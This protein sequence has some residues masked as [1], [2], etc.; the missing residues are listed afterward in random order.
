MDKFGIRGMEMKLK[1]S[2]I[3]IDIVSYFSVLMVFTMIVVGVVVFSSWKSSSEEM[4]EMHEKDAHED[5]FTKMEAYLNIPLHIN[6]MS[7]YSIE[8]EIVDIDN[9]REREI[10]FAGILKSTNPNVYSFSYGTES[11]EYYGARRNAKNEIEIMRSDK[12]TLGNSTYYAAK[13]DLTAGEVV[14]RLGKFDP[15][16]RDWYQIAKEKGEPVFSPTYTHFVMNDLAISAAYPIYD[17]EGM[18]KGVLGTHFILSDINEYLNEIV[19]PKN[20][21]VFIFE[22]NT[23][24]VIAST[25]NLP[26]FIAFQDR[27]MERIKIDQ[28][29]NDIFSKAYQEYQ[30]TSKHEFLVEAEDD[31]HR[32]N[33]VEYE[34][35]GLDWI[36][37]TAIPH[38]QFLDP[39]MEG[40][41]FSLVFFILAMLVS[42]ALLLKKSNNFLRPIDNL[43]ETAEKFSEGDFTQRAVTFKND[44]VGKLSQAF[45]SMADKFNDSMSVSEEMMRTRAAQMEKVNTELTKETERIRSTLN[46]VGKGFIST[47]RFGDVTMMNR[48][49]E[50]LTGWTQ[51][52]AFGM[53]FEEVFS[54][55]NASTGERCHSLVVSV[56]EH[57]EQVD[58]HCEPILVSR[59]GGETPIEG[60]ASPIED[61]EGNRCGVVILFTGRKE[62]KFERLRSLS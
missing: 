62:E 33:I 45:N 39:I 12:E 35:N 17:A 30:A 55:V 24:E 27:P 18:L 15:R 47:D 26:K 32:V 42:L 25:E 49:A 41:W 16:T 9:E 40:F 1:K 43:I 8:N 38:N 59:D 7:H 29:E 20:A 22:K 60:M 51:E 23:G 10:Y 52:D 2:S 44:E 50:T 31:S 13:E 3:R 34:K 48:E 28:I 6:Q 56:F 46:S 36:V 5:I 19:A 11:G 14:E 54:V 37:I 4:I 58:F 61:E 57:G 21:S 53:P